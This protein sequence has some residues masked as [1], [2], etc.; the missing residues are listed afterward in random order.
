MMF[1][2]TKMTVMVPARR[3]PVLMSLSRPRARF[4]GEEVKKSETLETLR[5]VAKRLGYSGYQVD[6]YARDLYCQLYLYGEN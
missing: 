5:L 3:V 2:S 1:H 4:S 6:K